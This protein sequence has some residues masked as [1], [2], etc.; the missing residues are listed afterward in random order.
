M[1]REQLLPLGSEPADEAALE[2]PQSGGASGR[3][4]ALYLSLSAAAALR[5]PVCSS[6]PRRKLLRKRQSVAI[7]TFAG[8]RGP[9]VRSE[10][11]KIG[12]RV[13]S[14]E[15]GELFLGCGARA[16]SQRPTKE[17]SFDLNVGAPLERAPPPAPTSVT[18]RPRNCETQPP[19]QINRA[20]L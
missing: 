15:G 5:A 9:D 11:V 1:V 20:N 4:A 12:K 3:C 19:M 18:R 13:G 10:R 17:P 14:L 6:F 8:A 2:A 7:L 16:R